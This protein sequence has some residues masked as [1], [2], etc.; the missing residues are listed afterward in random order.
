MSAKVVPLIDEGPVRIVATANGFVYTGNVTEEKGWLR[1]SNAY[2]IRRW[3]TEKG[4]GQLAIDGKQANTLLDYCGIVRV[5]I[6]AVVF[7]I[8]CQSELLP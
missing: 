8:D 1:I 4:L 3:G 5:P 2:N 6:H 7:L